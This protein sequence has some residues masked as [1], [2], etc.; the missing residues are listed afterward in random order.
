M[1]IYQFMNIEEW[2][3]LSIHVI[4]GSLQVGSTLPMCGCV[5]ECV[6]LRLTD[7]AIYVYWCD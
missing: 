5:P 3:F 6:L 7:Q 2:I 1:S 4:V